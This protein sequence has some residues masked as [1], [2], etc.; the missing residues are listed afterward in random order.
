[1]QFGAREAVGGTAFF[2]STTPAVAVTS[3]HLVL[4]TSRGSTLSALHMVDA[5]TKAVR[6]DALGLAMRHGAAY[7]GLDYSS[8]FAFVVCNRVPEDAVVCDLSASAATEGEPVDILVCPS[9]GSNAQTV[10]Q[11]IVVGVFPNRLEVQI[12]PR[13]DT[14]ATA[15][16]PI[17]SQA[18]GKVV[19][20]LQ[21]VVSRDGQGLV[22]GT[23]SVQIAA[24]ARTLKPDAQP[25][26]LSTWT[27]KDR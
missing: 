7:S 15:G 19:G 23:P 8:D 12:A 11:G 3:S 17:F 26:K 5:D 20:V 22:V 13:Q 1:M 14:R 2:V 21:N 4:F 25:L 10:I 9:D 27:E 16:S 6:A 18:T 24:A